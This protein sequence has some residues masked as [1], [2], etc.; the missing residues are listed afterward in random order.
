MDTIKNGTQRLGGNMPPWKDRLSDEEIELIILWFQSKW[1]QQLYEAWQRMD[2]E[3][4]Q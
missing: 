4:K 2:R 1:P 3:S